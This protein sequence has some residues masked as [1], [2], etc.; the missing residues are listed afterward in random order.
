[1]K[2]LLFVSLLLLLSACDRSSS[3]E[4]Q[5]KALQTIQS[6]TATAH[7]VG[8]TWQQGTVPDVYAQQTLAK[9]Q[10]EIAKETQGLTV[11]SE[12]KQQLQQVQQTLQQMTIAVEQK[13]QAA[14]A[15]SLQTLSKEQHQ[16]SAF[17][18]AQG[19]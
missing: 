19:K 18:T 4:K 5:N 3:R 16:L 12:L 10:Q 7:M 6:W 8:E 2:N 9:S 13:N 17:A 11:S 15:S 14:I 1:M